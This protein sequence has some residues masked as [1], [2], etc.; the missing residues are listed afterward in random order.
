MSLSRSSMEFGPVQ[1][2]RTLVSETSKKLKID[3]KFGFQVKMTDFEGLRL[4]DPRWP[5]ITASS[6]E[7]DRVRSKNA[8]KMSL[9]GS[10]ECF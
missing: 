2:G 5:K 3:S 9:E 8:S 1:N 4:G 6:V 7:C 10:D